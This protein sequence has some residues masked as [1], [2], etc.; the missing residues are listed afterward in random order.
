[1][2]YIQGE[3]RSYGTL[4]P[5]VLDELVPVDHVCGVIDPFVDTLVMTELGFERAK[6]AETPSEL[7]A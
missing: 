1:M 4:F 5:V 6:A 3:G 2:A 7:M